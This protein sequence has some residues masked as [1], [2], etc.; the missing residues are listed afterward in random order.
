MNRTEHIK[1]K[2][3]KIITQNGFNQFVLIDPNGYIIQQEI[4][5]DK[6]LLQT[7]AMEKQPQALTQQIHA[8]KKLMI[9]IK[10][11]AFAIGKD[12]FKAFTISRKTGADVF[13]IPIGKFYMG[14]I[15]STQVNKTSNID[16]ML[17]SIVNTQINNLCIELMG[18]S[19]QGNI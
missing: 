3:R 18:L 2:I 16:D 9:T 5:F 13:I 19:K 15:K 7:Q 14:M 8:L 6:S 17:K 12:K 1:N 11:S 10:N 4:K